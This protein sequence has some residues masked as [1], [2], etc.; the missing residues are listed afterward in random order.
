VLID[1]VLTQL[2]I[3][4]LTIDKRMIGKDLVE[5]YKKKEAQKLSSQCDH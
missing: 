5:E 3:D 4:Y 2:Q 1:D